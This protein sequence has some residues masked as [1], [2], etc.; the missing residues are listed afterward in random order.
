VVWRPNVAAAVVDACAAQHPAQPARAPVRAWVRM[1]R[2]SPRPPCCC[3]HHRFQ[4]RM[5]S[6]RALTPAHASMLKPEQP[7]SPP[8]AFLHAL[9]SWLYPCPHLRAHQR[10]VRSPQCPC[11]PFRPRHR[12][13]W[14]RRPSRRA[15]TRAW[16]GGPSNPLRP[17]AVRGCCGS[18]A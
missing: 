8:W 9:W 11:L 15:D 10:P 14:K 12:R 3:P 1:H 17:G 2:D 7:P 13:R 18:S 5:V 6:A 4:V 16:P